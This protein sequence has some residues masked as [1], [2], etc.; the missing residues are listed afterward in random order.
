MNQADF[1]F[2]TKWVA[3][4]ARQYMRFFEDH[5]PSFE[6]CQE[7]AKFEFSMRRDSRCPKTINASPSQQLLTRAH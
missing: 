3:D 5:N 2:K 6:Q 4:R 7:M 1:E